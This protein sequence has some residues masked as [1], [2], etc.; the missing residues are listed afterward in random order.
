MENDGT[1]QIRYGFYNFSSVLLIH[2]YKTYQSTCRKPH[3]NNSTQIN[4]NMEYCARCDWVH[5]GITD[6][7]W[8]WRVMC[9]H[10]CSMETSAKRWAV[11]VMTSFSQQL[12]GFPNKKHILFLST[13]CNPLSGK[14]GMGVSLSF[15][16]LFLQL[17]HNSC[18]VWGLQLSS[19]GGR[20]SSLNKHMRCVCSPMNNEQ[21]QQ[22]RR[23][24]GTQNTTEVFLDHS[25][26]CKNV[27]CPR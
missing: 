6:I 26:Q 17:K 4:T 18:K 2:W 7:T 11:G 22:S 15:P 25:M 24:T 19:V 16:L 14:E 20:D 13:H 23:W 10:T 12:W 1:V 9:A 8:V 5:L 3:W 27:R 21:Q